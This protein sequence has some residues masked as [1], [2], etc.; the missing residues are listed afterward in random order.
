MGTKKLQNLVGTIEKH[1]SLTSVVL[2]PVLQEFADR[3]IGTLSSAQGKYIYKYWDRRID[4]AE[5]AASIFDFLKERGFAHA[6]ELLHTRDGTNTLISDDGTL[7]LLVYVE[8]DRPAPKP[9]N[10]GQLGQIL[11]E[12]NSI[13]DYPYDS[14]MTLAGLRPDLAKV[15]GRLGG[16]TP[17]GFSSWLADCQIWISCLSR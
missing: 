4:T 16:R 1:W 17:H 10:Y 3:A 11:G 9:D 5:Q 7:L 2:G 6:P 15:A 14:P 8:G 13:D 12:L